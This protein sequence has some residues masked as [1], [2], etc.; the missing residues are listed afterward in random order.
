MREL[1]WDRLVTQELAGERI[2]D[3]R[4]LIADDRILDARLLEVGPDGAE[5]P[6]GDDEDAQAGR[7]GASD[8]G[9]GAWPQRAVRPDQCP[10]EVAGEDVDLA[11]ER[12]RQDQPRAVTT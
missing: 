3:D 6:A 5:H 4:T 1:G 7:A 9:E 8:R 12:R 2:G 11:R 10:V